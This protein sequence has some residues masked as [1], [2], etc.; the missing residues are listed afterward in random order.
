[1][2]LKDKLT[3]IGTITLPV[4]AHQLR[5]APNLARFAFFKFADCLAYVTEDDGEK[6][7]IGNVGGVVGGHYQI[8]LNRDCCRSDSEATLLLDR[9][10]VWNAV[11][12]LF[13]SPAA[14]EI[15]AQ[16]QRRCTEVFEAK[17]VAYKAEKLLKL[18]QEISDMQDRKEKLARELSTGT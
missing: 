16:L 9:E 10:E 11:T 5:D 1:M 8:H 17:S 2:S 18:K 14:Q 13:D 3:P 12:Q 15:V 4:Y 6:R 7:D